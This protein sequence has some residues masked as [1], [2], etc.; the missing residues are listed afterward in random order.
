MND[1]MIDFNNILVL[2]NQLI[3]V[4]IEELC[5]LYQDKDRYISFLDS[6]AL[7]SNKDS[8]FLFFSGEFLNK[9][10]SVVQI[11]RFDFD[12]EEVNK[13]INS[14]ITYINQ[15]SNYSSSLVNLLKNHYLI[16]QEE[17]RET[18]FNSDDELFRSLAYDAWV[19]AALIDGNLESIQDGNLFLL[20]FNFLLKNCPELF[21]DKNVRDNAT[22]LLDKVGKETRIIGSKRRKFKEAKKNFQMVVKRED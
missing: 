21:Q 19:F 18:K 8:A 7:L 5:K 4:P 9:I 20:S 13:V 14:I 3:A 12:D 15:I 2:R 11:H 6:V 16:F 17:Q 10:L 1:E 22:A